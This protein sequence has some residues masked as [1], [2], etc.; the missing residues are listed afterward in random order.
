MV[1]GEYGLIVDLQGEDVHPWRCL[2]VEGEM[3]PPLEMPKGDDGLSL[4]GFW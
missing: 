2:R 4:W 1:V 3:A